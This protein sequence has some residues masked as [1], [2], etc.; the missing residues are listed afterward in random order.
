MFLHT[1]CHVIYRCVA[2]KP[3]NRAV[4]RMVPGSL[5]GGTPPEFAPQLLSLG[6]SHI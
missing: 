1:R 6:K 5:F 3:C 2:F 4:E